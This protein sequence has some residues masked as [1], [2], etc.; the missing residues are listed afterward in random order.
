[1]YVTCNIPRG[2]SL[3]LNHS[4]RTKRIAVSLF[5]A[6]MTCRATAQVLLSEF[7]VRVSPESVALWAKASGE[8]RKRGEKSGPPTGSELKSAYVTGA[9]VRQLARDYHVSQA[10]VRHRLREEGVRM[11][12][13]GT[14]YPVLTADL[15]RELYGDR[16]LSARRIAARVGCSEATVAWR[17][18][19]YGIPRK[20][21]RKVAGGVLHAGE[22]RHFRP[23]LSSRE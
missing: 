6:G 7:G 12:P 18:R 16:G 3:L 11:R 21:R 13:S 15:L 4:P 5:H 20:H 17:L 22:R 19:A 2:L 8:F 14:L 23:S 10:L 1:M 9:S